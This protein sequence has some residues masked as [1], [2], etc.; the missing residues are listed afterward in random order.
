MSQQPTQNTN[1]NV[2][3]KKGT[4]NKK[5][6]N[7]N[8][9][10]AGGPYPS[11]NTPQQ[12]TAPLRDLE[13][14]DDTQA[15]KKS[16][17]TSSA[18]PRKA[19]T[20]KEMGKNKERENE[21]DQNFP[22]LPAIA[23]SSGGITVTAATMQNVAENSHSNSN[24]PSNANKGKILATRGA[25]ANSGTTTL[26][27]YTSSADQPPPA[28]TPATNSTANQC[29]VTGMEIDTE[30]GQPTNVQTSQ[31]G[32]NSR[33][34]PRVASQMGDQGTDMA[35][36]AR[37]APTP[38]LHFVRA[39]SNSTAPSR[40]G[41]PP[42]PAPT[43]PTI[44]PA[45]AAQ[46]ISML[47]PP[48]TNPSPTPVAAA[49]T[50]LLNPPIG[51]QAQTNGNM[52]PYPSM[53]NAQ[54]A[55]SNNLPPFAPVTIL[56]T[57]PG[58]FPMALLGHNATTLRR[59]QLQAHRQEWDQVFQTSGGLLL[60]PFNGIRSRTQQ[61]AAVAS[62]CLAVMD[63]L[64]SPSNPIVAY[65]EPDP[66]GDS[67]PEVLFTTNL[68]GADIQTLL[69]RQV[70]NTSHGTFFVTPYNAPP[71]RFITNIEGFTYSPEQR[72][73]LEQLTR[74]IMS[75][76]PRLTT[77][78]TGHRDAV[79]ANFIT[80]DDVVNTVLNTVEMRPMAMAVSGGQTRTVWNLFMEPPSLNIAHH[81][82]LVA[83]INAIA[84]RTPLFGTGRQMRNPVRCNH[85]GGFD[86]PSGHC[87]FP[88][89][90]GWIER[91]NP[92]PPTTNNETIPSDRGQSAR[93]RG[94][95]TTRGRSAPRGRRG[96]RG[97]RGRGQVQYDW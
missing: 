51:A 88:T 65:A 9:N 77:F 82:E 69:D 45:T 62:A 10:N 84:F 83:I 23:Q 87:P 20:A 93:G 90:P 21:T 18:S 50:P 6:S 81:N 42:V 86:H 64:P 91:S 53:F 89:I 55:T 49:T 12:T 43:Q 60:R 57:P 76:Q 44:A 22:R 67:I 16:A 8:G 54:G 72:Q 41:L 78:I 11:Q 61:E 36:R 48:L 96:G 38:T 52:N 24:P 46:T 31:T 80:S 25:A 2:T 19:W 40:P 56:L 66:N 85:C 74:F 29:P 15:S 73:E 17:P 28:P 27:Q 7:V 32:E 3:D 79:P 13:M 97:N 63:A 1:E 47:Q 14:L 71:S 30:V 92:N 59:N 58:G 68:S 95:G 34:R 26:P 35:N 70:L 33:K 39:T 94:G 4:A 37:T 5:S 75:R